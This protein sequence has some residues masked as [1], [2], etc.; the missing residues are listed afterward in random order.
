[1]GKSVPK[2]RKCL[3]TREVEIIRRL[4]RKLKLPIT[5]IALAVGRDRTTVYK[6]LR[7]TFQ[8]AEA[9]AA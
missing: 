4:K 6:A 5:K 1:M 9:R 2:S 8:A 7:R 3:G